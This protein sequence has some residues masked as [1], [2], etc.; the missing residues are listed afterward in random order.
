[1][2]LFNCY[3]MFEQF[4]HLN[5]DATLYYKVCRFYNVD[6]CAAYIRSLIIRLAVTMDRLDSESIRLIGREAGK[7]FAINFMP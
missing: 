7:L 1:M 3:Q 4:R 6:Y 2:D 5:A